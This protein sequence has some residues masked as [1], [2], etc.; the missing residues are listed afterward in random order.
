MRHL[1][2]FEE[3]ETFRPPSE[4]ELSEKILQAL[5]DKQQTPATLAEQ[6]PDDKNMLI[7]VLH[8]LLDEGK[9]IAVNGMIQIKK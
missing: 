9:V 4:K 2:Q 6:I 8:E 5:S 3:Q 7:D 1:H